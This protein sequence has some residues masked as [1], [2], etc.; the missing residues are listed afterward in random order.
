LIKKRLTA[1]IID[2][3]HYFSGKILTLIRKREIEAKLE[4]YDVIYKKHAPDLLSYQA[5]KQQLKEME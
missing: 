4:L 1:N 5:L 3:K 2:R